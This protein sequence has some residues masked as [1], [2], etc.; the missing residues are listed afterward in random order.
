M[1]S[2]GGAGG[3]AGVL[4]SLDHPRRVTAVLQ[5]DPRV[6]LTA[7][8][9]GSLRV[10]DLRSGG[11]RASHTLERAHATRIRGLA[12]LVPGAWLLA[13]AAHVQPGGRARA[14]WW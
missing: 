14:A 6:L 12:A 2:V 10:W 4:C 11:A 8:E 7:L 9:D 5:Q 1:H 3:A 13:H